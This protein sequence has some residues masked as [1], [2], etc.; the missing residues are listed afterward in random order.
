VGDCPEEYKLFRAARY[1]G[2]PPWKLAKRSVVWLEWAVL[3]DQAEIQASKI[4]AK[5]EETRA[6]HQKKRFQ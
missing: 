5:T 3:F 4:E 2:V 1:L 6:E